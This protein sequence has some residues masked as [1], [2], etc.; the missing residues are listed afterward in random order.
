MRPIAERH[1][2]TPMQ[3]ACTWDLAHEPVRCVTPTLIEEPGSVKPIEAK[4]AELAA[5]PA[6]VVLAPEE[7][8]EL[9][10]I[11]DNTGSMRL[12][13]ASPDFDGPA[14]PDGW[15]VDDELA[16]VAARWAIDPERQLAYS[17]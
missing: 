15:P 10:E 4:R 1:G 5:V 7:V 13:G 12:K 8:A 3:L 6:R 16:A 9:R 14:Q 2:L 17:G 11:G